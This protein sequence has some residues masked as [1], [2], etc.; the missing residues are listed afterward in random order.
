MGYSREGLENRLNTAYF[1]L[2]RQIEKTL[3][4]C[5]LA[6]GARRDFQEVCN[7]DNARLDELMDSSQD[8]AICPLFL[9]LSLFVYMYL[10]LSSTYVLR[11]NEFNVTGGDAA[12]SIA[13][14]S[15]HRSNDVLRSL[16]PPSLP[17]FSS[18]IQACRVLH[19]SLCNDYNAAI[20]LAFS[21][22]IKKYCLKMD[23]EYT[24][25]SSTSGGGLD[26]WGRI[27]ESIVRDASTELRGWTISES[28]RDN[29]LQPLRDHG[30]V[31]SAR[32]VSWE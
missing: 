1:D 32:M 18:T 9:F 16:Y 21:N 19:S 5:S 30:D 15:C 29:Y 22:S 27:A 3:E 26:G 25:A 13:A 28:L 10:R 24:K 4:G 31:L 12:M 6:D 14:V 7:S 20:V 23:A 8:H 11:I 2:D 17:S